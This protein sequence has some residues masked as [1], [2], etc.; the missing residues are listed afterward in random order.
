LLQV[1]GIG[2]SGH[3]GV[4]QPRTRRRSIPR[5]WNNAVPWS[6]EHVRASMIRLSPIVRETVI[7]IAGARIA[8]GMED[9]KAIRIAIARARPWSV[10][11]R[12]PLRQRSD[13]HRSPGP[14]SQRRTTV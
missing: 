5:W 3:G 10:R 11:R 7:E 14:P 6:S 1:R 4:R 8:D 2:G 9:G 12:V 13:E